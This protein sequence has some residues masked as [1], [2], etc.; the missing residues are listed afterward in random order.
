MTNYNLIIPDIHQNLDRLNQILS[1]EDAKNA[2]E[3]IFL[4][5]YFDSFD[6]DFNTKE[7]CNFLN[8]NVNNDRYTFLLGN[9]DAHYLTKVNKYRCSG[10]SFQKQSIVDTTLDK[11]FLRKIKPFRYEKI[12][13]KHFL[14]SHAGLHPSFTPFC[15]NEMLKGSSGYDI[16]ETEP[17]KEWF[18]YKEQEIKDSI[19]MN[20]YNTWL[21]AGKDR[22]GWETHGGVT[23]MD[24]CSLR[25][26][27][28]LNQI[29][30]HSTYSRPQSYNTPQGDINLNLDTNLKHY[31]K[32]DL[33]TAE[34]EVMSIVGRVD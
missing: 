22:G 8:K 33:D 12:A 28:F 18:L 24:W 1:T 34:V 23:W 19:F 13:G 17:V 2:K 29:V 11:A 7:M 10:W 4:G 20:E 14:F 3:I 16:V 15:F 9:H 6:Y 5:D 27:E 26:I 32:I 31:A 30:G 25:E 21:G